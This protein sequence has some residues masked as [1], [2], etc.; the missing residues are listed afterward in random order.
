[1]GLRSIVKLKNVKFWTSIL[2]RLRWVDGTVRS[3]LS[4]NPVYFS[5]VAVIQKLFLFEFLL[6][7]RCV[8]D[9]LPGTWFFPQGW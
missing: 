8:R 2:I 5:L 1:M 3:S 7:A 6:W 9:L 4:L